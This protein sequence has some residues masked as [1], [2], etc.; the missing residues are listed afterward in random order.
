M[1]P[2]KNHMLQDLAKYKNSN[3][4][5][6]ILKMNELQQYESHG[7]SFDKTYQKDP[8]IKIACF[9]SYARLQDCLFL[10]S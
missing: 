5:R 2:K 3:D 1:K 10:C 8:K 6:T 7:L 4:K 9:Y